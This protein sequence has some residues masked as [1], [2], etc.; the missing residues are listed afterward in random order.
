MSKS[1]PLKGAVSFGKERI[2]VNS[3]SI[4]SY[5]TTDNLLPNKLGVIR[6][7]SLPPQAGNI[8]AYNCENILFGNIRPYLKKIWF[9][10]RSGG[11]S[12][13]ILV[14]QAKPGYFPKFIYYALLRDDFFSH[15]MKG[16]KGT[17]MPRGDKAQ[18]LEFT[19][20]TIGFNDQQKI[21]AVLSVLDA[22]ID[23]NN[24]INTELEA[25]AKTL[26][27]YWFVQFDFPDANGKPYKS[28]GGKMVYN[29][30]LKREIPAG[31]QHSTIGET[32][33]THLGGT[34][35]REKEEYWTPSEVNWLSS[36]ENPST[37]VVDPDERISNLGLQ[38]S[39]AKLLPEGTV[40]L[41]IVRHLRASILGIE[42]ATNQSVVGIVES[43]AFKH[44][45]IY[46]YLVREIPRLMVL[47]TGAQQPHINKGVL[48]E[49][50]LVVPDASTLEAYTSLAAPLFLQIKNYHQQNW[51]LTQLR[52]WLLPMLMNGQ[53]T[54]A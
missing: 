49:S 32:F 29:A 5:V 47:R 24:R 52:D 9:S 11:C 33:K 2:S 4:D 18:I 51:E 28:S 46:P 38:N 19:I 54:V 3:A 17:K 1:I 50:L 45:F 48:D 12:A 42:A 20:P 21:V 8:P 25:M 43:S 44:C 23:C 13:D 31:W 16:A 40:I 37:F 26:Y 35:S 14:F 22:K 53:V 36:G 39:P 34:P 41:S 10:D 6:A 27:D 7:V 15:V 30:T